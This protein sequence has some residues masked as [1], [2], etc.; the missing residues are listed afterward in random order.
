MTYAVRGVVTPIQDHA[1]LEEE[2]HPRLHL[3]RQLHPQLV[4]RVVTLVEMVKLAVHLSLVK[5]AV[6][7]GGVP[8]SRQ[9]RY[10]RNKSK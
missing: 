5:L 10:Y 4:E 1:A 9:M 8:V 2:N 7:A 3:H 6:Q